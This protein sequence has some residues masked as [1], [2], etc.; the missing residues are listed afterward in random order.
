[1]DRWA[2]IRRKAAELLADYETRTGRPAFEAER[3][4][5]AVLD[6]IAERCFRLTVAE[7]PD[8]APGVLGQLDLDEGTILTAPGLAP[9]RRA[10]VI[11]H[12]LG[13]RAL[14]HPARRIEDSEEQ[15]VEA[16]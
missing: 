1:M 4:S 8:L 9:A 6:P 12:E 15:I 13:H 2:S 3:G 16:P 10:F 5:S 7:D 14:Q 11:A